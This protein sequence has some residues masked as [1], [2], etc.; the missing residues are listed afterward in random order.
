MK[1]NWQH[2]FK[3][4]MLHNDGLQIIHKNQLWNK[5]NLWKLFPVFLSAKQIN[6]FCAG[7]HYFCLD[8]QFML[9]YNRVVLFAVFY[10]FDA[11][12]KI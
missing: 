5:L 3:L 6:H 8:H 2:N 11:S 4:E 10:F 1:N 12:L 7:F 9:T